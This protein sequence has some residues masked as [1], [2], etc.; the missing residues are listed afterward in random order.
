MPVTFSYCVLW[1]A[2]RLP[3]R[4]FARHGDLSYG[5]YIYA[6]PIQ[7]LLAL[8]GLNRWRSE[9]HTSELQSQSNL[10]C[11]LLLEKKKNNHTHTTTVASFHLLHGAAPPRPDQSQ[12]ITFLPLFSDLRSHIA[13]H[14]HRMYTRQTATYHA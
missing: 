4:R 13:P 5:T 3:I 7:Q 11:R 14:S 12:T 1:L 10:V 2:F 8:Y 6:F 9:E